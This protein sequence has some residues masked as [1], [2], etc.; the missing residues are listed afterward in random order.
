MDLT[1]RFDA[2]SAKMDELKAKAEKASKEVKE[3]W[4]QGIADLKA[5][6]EFTRA[7]IDE[8]AA[9][10]ERKHDLKVEERIDD[11]IAASE[12]VRESFAEGAANLKADG[13]AFVS[14]LKDAAVEI[15]EQTEI[16]DAKIAAKREEKAEKH[17]AKI[18]ELRDRINDLGQA[19]ARA[20][21]EELIL[22]LLE[23]ADDCQAIAVYMAEEAAIAYKAAA[24]EIAIYKAKYGA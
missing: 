9:D 14:D 16:A 8:I 6:M 18:E 2:V 1:E 22:E 24:N 7:N 11:A 21:Q 12:A 3:S 4:T 5:D 15:D 17:R 13:D 19:H 10:A 23:Y 20:D